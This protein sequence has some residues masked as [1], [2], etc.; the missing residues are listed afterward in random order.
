MVEEIEKIEKDEI[1]EQHFKN[2][3]LDEEEERLVECALIDGEECMCPILETK[4]T[5]YK[6]RCTVEDCDEEIVGVSRDDVVT[7]AKSHLIEHSSYY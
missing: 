5:G 6:F 7:K 2:L 1:E 3:D 4:I